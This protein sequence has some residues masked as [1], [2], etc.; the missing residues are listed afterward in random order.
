MNAK[1]SNKNIKVSAG[2]ISMVDMAYWKRPVKNGESIPQTKREYVEKRDK[3][4]GTDFKEF[5]VNKDN[6]PRWNWKVVTKVEKI[7]FDIPTFVGDVTTT[8]DMDKEVT[9][10]D[11]NM[12]N[13]DKYRVTKNLYLTRS[14]DRDAYEF[15][16]SSDVVANMDSSNDNT[17]DENR[18]LEYSLPVKLVKYEQ[19]DQ[20]SM[21]A[22]AM[23]SIA[24]V[25]ES[26]DGV[27]I[28]L[29]FQPKEMLFGGV[30]MKGHLYKFATYASLDDIKSH[31]RYT[32]ANVVKESN[33]TDDGK[34]FPGEFEFVRDS[35]GE[36][37]IG[38]RVWVDAMDE[39]AKKG[40]NSIDASQPAVLML[41]WSKAPNDSVLNKNTKD[42]NSLDSVTSK[43]LLKNSL[44]IAEKLLDAGVI[45]GRSKEI[46]EKAVER[47]R[48]A[49]K[50]NNKMNLHTANEIILFAIDNV[51]KESGLK[52]TNDALMQ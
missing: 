41:D 23:E 38:V 49:L 51:K 2:D 30:K 34:T 40:N 48:Q 50:S 43:T 35:R 3:L 19:E 27:K 1:A 37:K 25:V 47:A 22:D 29:K 14:S 32:E 6:G 39:V 45:E 44:V 17:T 20:A 7:K 4:A 16:V 52:T 11:P 31:G 21:G 28:S 18:V 12:K 9:I 36:E 42:D 10:N 8:N 24:R 26:R 15:E 33:Y 13:G 5:L 46:L